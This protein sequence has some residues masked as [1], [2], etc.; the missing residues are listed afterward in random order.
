MAVQG[1]RTEQVMLGCLGICLCPCGLQLGWLLLF[2]C[3]EG[4]R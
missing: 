1:L 3:L 4:I 2:R